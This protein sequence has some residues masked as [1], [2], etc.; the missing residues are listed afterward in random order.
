MEE[1]KIVYNV[2]TDMWKLAKEY[3]CQAM[4]NEQAEEFVKKGHSLCEKYSQ[5]GERIE[6]LCRRLFYA[7]EMYYE[8]KEKDG[9]S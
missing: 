7:I 5:Y 3:S 1:I 6:L 9:K 8:S 2:I 4:S